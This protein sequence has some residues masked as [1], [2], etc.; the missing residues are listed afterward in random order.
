MARHPR[1]HGSAVK[2]GPRDKER[3]VPV[4]VSL[5]PALKLQLETEAW[6]CSRTLADYIRGLLERRGKWARTVG[7]A[8]G[9][10]LAA[11]ISRKKDT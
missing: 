4:T 5:S 3:K 6:E 11:P 9:Y 8:G 2:R 1:R 10:D 7:K